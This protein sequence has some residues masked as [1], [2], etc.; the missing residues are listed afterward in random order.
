MALGLCQLMASEDVLTSDGRRIQAHVS[1]SNGVWKIGDTTRPGREVLV[2]RFSPVPPPER[3]TAGVFIRSGSLLSGPLN[4]LIGDVAEVDNS[5]F[6]PLN[7][8]R[9]DIAAAFYPLLPGQAENMPELARYSSLLS[10]ALGSPGALLQPYKQCRVRFQGLDELDAEQIMRVGKDQI[11][12]T[13]KSQGV[14]SVSRQF[15]RMIELNPPPQPPQP[16]QAPQPAGTP[17]QE[18]ARLGP[19]VLVRLLGGDLLRGRLLSLDDKALTLRTSFMGEQQ[20]ERGTL[21]VVFLSGADGSGVSWLSG[22]TPAKSVQTPLF[23]AD[24]PPRM[25]TS[26]DGGNI[27]V[28]DLACERGIGVHSRSRLDFSLPGTPQRFLTLCGIDAE[29]GGRGCVVA[30]VLA[31]GKE[32]WKSSAVT[33]KDAAQLIVLDLGS[34]KTLSLLVD[35]GPGGP[36]GPEE[37]DS[38]GHFDWGW[39]AIM[40]K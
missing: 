19:E 27:R 10:A 4:S 24:F 7:L 1:A 21:A 22:R 33:G 16:P 13:T 31:D 2:V 29:T 8:K 9:D 39:A 28:K 35:W 25:D 3:M 15:V 37:N 40:P 30:R 23:D 18:E 11:L 14:E 17:A 38:G 6:G 12:L 36:G 26:V 5:A 20:I 34:A 32:L